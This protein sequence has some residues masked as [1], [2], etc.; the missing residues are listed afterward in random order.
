MSDDQAGRLIPLPRPAAA[1]PEP[2]LSAVIAKLVWSVSE[3]WSAHIT[4]AECALLLSLFGPQASRDT[5]LDEG[6]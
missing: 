2:L 5:P 3:G 4:P 1:C 6:A